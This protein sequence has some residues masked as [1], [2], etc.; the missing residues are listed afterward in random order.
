MKTFPNIHLI[1]KTL[2]ANTFKPQ[3]LNT[4]F[5]CKQ[6]PIILQDVVTYSILGDNNQGFSLSYFFIDR[7]NGSIYLRQPLTN[8]N[9]N[10]FVVS[11][12]HILGF[13]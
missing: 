1:I 8:I 12:F 10:Q 3:S 2:P 13:H 5:T 11:R 4:V 7:T 6:C 9:V